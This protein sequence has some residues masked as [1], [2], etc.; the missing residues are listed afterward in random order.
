MVSILPRVD[1][2]ENTEMDWF[3]ILPLFRLDSLILCSISGASHPVELTKVRM[4]DKDTVGSARTDSLGYFT[5]SGTAGGLFSEPKLYI[6]VE[7]EYF[8]E[9]GQMDIQRELFGFNRHERTSTMI[10]SSFID[11]GNITFSSDHCRAYVMVY[12]AMED[13][14]RGTGKYLPY[15]RLKVVT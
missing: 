3:C 6:E 15:N 9:Y 1:L 7:Y 5:V 4:K 12:Q 14:I 2:T 10:Y 13:F 11:F 8:G